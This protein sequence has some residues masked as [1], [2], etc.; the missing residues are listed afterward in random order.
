[1]VP[2]EE[3]GD[4]TPGLAIFLR[5]CVPAVFFVDLHQ[6]LVG[7]L[8]SCQT[9]LRFVGSELHPCLPLHQR[10]ADLH[11]H[12]LYGVGA[13]PA[14]LGEQLHADGTSAQNIPSREDWRHNPDERWVK[15]EVIFKGEVE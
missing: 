8:C 2:G 6:G 10:G 9:I 5:G 12:G 3:E 11:D 4:D 13:A 7:L 15:G 1:M 14:L